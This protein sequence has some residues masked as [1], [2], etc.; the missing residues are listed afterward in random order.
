MILSR[1]DDSILDRNRSYRLLSQDELSNGKT[2]NWPELELSGTI[3]NLSPSVWKLTHLTALYAND[4]CLKSLPPSIALLQNL[5]RLDLA[6]NRLRAIPAEI[7]DLTELRELILNNNLLRTLPP[8][9]GKL[10]QLLNLGLKGNQLSLEIS[11]IYNE[12]NGMRKL[13][14]F[15]LDN[16]SG[17]SNYFLF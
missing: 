5:R 17:K 12:P 2:T 14:D 10:F 1:G 15:M 11:S 6:N 9:I 16:M 13:L 8:E 4:N 7:G 3:R